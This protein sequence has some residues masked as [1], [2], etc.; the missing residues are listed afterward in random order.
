M[1]EDEAKKKACCVK[2]LTVTGH[3]DGSNCMAWRWEKEEWPIL[4]NFKRPTGE[5]KMRN[6]K[7]G[8]CGR[9]GKP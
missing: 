8:Y 9:A 6:S 4:D 7:N 5:M 2:D 3:C 1:T